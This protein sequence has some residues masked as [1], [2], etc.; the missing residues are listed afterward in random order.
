MNKSN[1][2]QQLIRVAVGVIISP[3]G[4]ILIARRPNHVSQGGLWEF[5]GGKV[6][7]AE[8]VGVA[9]RRELWE[10]IGIELQTVNPEPFLYIYHKY[11]EE[12]VLL[13]VCYVTVYRGEPNSREG[14]ALAWV[15]LK[16]ITDF[17]FPDA[18]E[19]ILTHLY[20]KAGWAA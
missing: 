1:N 15:S 16:D 9:I 18:N 6:E 11:S 13:E 17:P 8:T 14:Q 7:K 19:P 5:P 4:K 10:E 20:E 3:V 2:Q 12:T